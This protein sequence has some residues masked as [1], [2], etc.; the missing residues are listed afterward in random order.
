MIAR[1]AL[2]ISGDLKIIWHH[3]SRLWVG[4]KSSN[5]NNQKTLKKFEPDT[6]T[7][8]TIYLKTT[9]DD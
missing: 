4:Y 2:Q 3:F 8:Y 5:L 1:T 7:E 6:K 9:Y